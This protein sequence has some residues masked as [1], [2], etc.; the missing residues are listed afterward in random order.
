M[1]CRVKKV[2]LKCNK[3]FNI[4]ASFKRKPNA[5]AKILRLRLRFAQDDGRLGYGAV[6]DYAVRCVAFY[7][8]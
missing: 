4:S 2:K 6:L 5:S 7:L 3:N 8:R 1:A